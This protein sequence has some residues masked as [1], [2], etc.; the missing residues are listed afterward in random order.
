LERNEAPPIIL[1]SSYASFDNAS[2]EREIPIEPPILTSTR[3]VRPFPVFWLILWAILVFLA[4]SETYMLVAKPGMPEDR[5]VLESVREKFEKRY[6]EAKTDEQKRRV[7]TAAEAEISKLKFEN[8]GTEGSAGRVLAIIRGELGMHGPFEGPQPNAETDEFESDESKKNAEKARAKLNEVITMIYSGEQIDDE[9]KDRYRKIILSTAGRKWPFDL[10]LNRLSGKADAVEDLTEMGPAALIAGILLLGGIG[11]WVAYVGLT[12]TGL[13]PKGLPRENVFFEVSDN[14]ALRFILY[15]AAFAVLPAGAMLALKPLDVPMAAELAA[16][17]T[18]LAATGIIVSAELLGIR[19]SLRRLGVRFDSF[20]Q[21]VVWGVGGFLA[22]I[23]V[24]LVLI[25]VSDLFL[26]KLPSGD[27]PIQQEIFSEGGLARAILS[28]VV[29]AP[30]VEE[31]FFR[32]CLYQGL[33]ARMKSWIWPIAISS[34]AFASLHPQGVQA[35]LVLGW[36]G[37]M[38][39]LLFRQTG[40]IVPAIIMHALNNLG[41]ILLALHLQ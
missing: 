33:A 1:E 5:R 21:Q 10:A 32:G 3:P 28:A 19:M 39:C 38:G 12:M 11:A 27:H 40:S 16:V 37:A 26:Q 30:I 15:I 18:M 2:T 4:A 7:L 36:I 23:P 8:K 22:N 34:I 31:V 41:A 6:S 17:L 14:L 35:W 9:A 25:L 13:R 29:M 24:L 20:F